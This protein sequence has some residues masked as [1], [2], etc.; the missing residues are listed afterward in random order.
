MGELSDMAV[1][2]RMRGRERLSEANELV[3]DDFALDVE[4]E[5]GSMGAKKASLAAR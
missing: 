2:A 1:S 3:E 5:E 4:E